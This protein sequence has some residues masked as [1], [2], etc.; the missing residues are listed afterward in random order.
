MIAPLDLQIAEELKN[1]LCKHLKV[2]EVRV[3][4]SRARGDSEPD[5]DLDVF[6]VLTCGDRRQKELVRSIAWEVGLQHGIVISAIV[7]DNHELK[8]TPL[9]SSPFVA[10]L[11]REGVTV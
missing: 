8:E 4:G 2:D 3:F 5:S 6:V 9:R 10:A 7:V 1:L 11:E